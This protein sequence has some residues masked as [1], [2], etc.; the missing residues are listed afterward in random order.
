MTAYHSLRDALRAAGKTI[1]ETGN[2]RFTAQCPGHDDHNP[3][4]AVTGIKGSVLLYCHAG[5]DTDHVLDSLGLTK[6]DLFDSPGGIEYVYPGGRTVRRTPDKNFPQSGNMGDRSL[7]GS[8]QIGEADHVLV[9]EG[10]KDVTAAQAV[11]VAAVSSAMGAGKAHRADWEPLRGKQITIVSDNDEPGLK[12]AGQVADQLA[13]V[14]VASTRIVHAAVGKDFADHVAAGKTLDDLI[15]VEMAAVA[16]PVE[17]AIE[18]RLNYLRID[19]EARRRLD[20]EQQPPAVPPPVKSLT[21]LLAEP[22]DPVTYRIDRVL[23]KG[24]NTMLAAPFKAGKTS[25]VGNLTRCLVD[26]DPFLGMFPVNEPAKAVVIADIELSPN[27]SRR[28]LRDSQTRNTDAVADVVSL[29]GAVSSFNLMDDDC[30][31]FWST[32]LRDLG[33]DYFIL[34]CLRPVLDAIGLD[35]NRDV[36]RFLVAFDRMLADAGVSDCLI[37]QHMGHNNERGRGDSRQLD[38]P[39]AT[40]TVVRETDK[41]DSPRYFSAFGRDVNVPEGRL[42]FNPANRHQTYRAGSRGEAKA[43]RALPAVVTVLAGSEGMSGRAVEE[44]ATAGGHKRDA[45]RTALKKAVEMELVSVENG[46]HNA[47]I[48]RIKH[49][50]AQCGMP[51]VSGDKR[52]RECPEPGDGVLFQ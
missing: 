25:L 35:E 37:V 24:G 32:R 30:R 17:S 52:H 13:A 3:S 26:G 31:R 7:Y 49:P 46:A 41:L 44:A 11:G 29:R 6:A 12:H 10:E 39:D 18:D 36:G 40:W 1:K 38:W 43:E 23:L 27:T 48:H 45:I 19:R 16:D 50:C 15:P 5:C 51:V 20:A 42:E 9:V 34:D 14:G 4:L 8:D 28:W 22:D 47:K 33:C 2:D 21:Q